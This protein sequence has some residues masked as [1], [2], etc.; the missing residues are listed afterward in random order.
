MMEELTYRST[1]QVLL[2][3][4]QPYPI[5]TVCICGQCGEAAHFIN[6]NQREEPNQLTDENM[7]ALW[8]ARLYLPLREMGI[9]VHSG[10]PGAKSGQLIFTFPNSKQFVR[11]LNAV[12]RPNDLLW[13]FVNGDRI[14]ER[15]YMHILLV[16]DFNHGEAQLDQVSFEELVVVIVNSEHYGQ[17]LAS[18]TTKYSEW[19][20]R[21]AF[22]EQIED[23]D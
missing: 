1:G 13:P 4:S 19:R 14:D 3:E 21:R 7:V 5:Y 8:M 12:I 18:L 9:L 10:G 20:T 23:E 2:F 6:F 11:F 15:E 16:D 22:E 17:M